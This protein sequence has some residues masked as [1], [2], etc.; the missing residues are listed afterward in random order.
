MVADVVGSGAGRWP[1]RTAARSTA[2]CRSPGGVGV[3]PIARG[4]VGQVAALR[5]AA[6]GEPRVSTHVST[7][8][9]LAWKSCTTRSSPRRTSNRSQSHSWTKPA[10]ESPGPISW[11]G[12][13][14][15][16][17]SRSSHRSSRASWL[18]SS[19]S[20][21]KPGGRPASTG[22]SNRILRANACSVPMGA[23]SSSSRAARRTALTRLGREH[24]AHAVAQLAGGLLGERDRGDRLDRHAL[25][26]ERDDPPDERA[27]LAGAGAG[28]DE[29]RRRRVGADAVPLG[30]V[31]RG[32][33]GGSASAPPSGAVA[34]GSKSSSSWPVTTRGSVGAG[35]QRASRSSWRLRSHSGQRSPVPR[36][37]GWQYLHLTKC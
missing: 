7:R 32:F 21:V 34:A 28:L 10:A 36:L 12:S 22:N 18:S 11:S 4:P 14:S 17:S 29:Q 26:D 33:D 15:R 16:L 6:A 9:Q 31:R 37:S 1:R 13:S 20:T 35:N 27:G 30:L 25:V 3:Q 24:L 2:S 5:A 8:S 19:S 23:P